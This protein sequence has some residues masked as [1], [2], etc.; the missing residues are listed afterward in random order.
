MA[1]R[2]SKAPRAEDLASEPDAKAPLDW[3]VFLQA[4]QPVL[5]LLQDD[6]RSRAKTSAS[7]G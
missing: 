7:V 1:T 3:Q 6:L 4:A 5:K 2:R